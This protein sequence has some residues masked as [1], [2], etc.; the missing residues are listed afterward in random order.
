MR[1]A[2]ADPA[3]VHAGAVPLRVTVG[4]SATLGRTRRVVEGHSR[5]AGRCR[6]VRPRRAPV[7]TSRTSGSSRATDRGRCAQTTSKFAIM[8][9]SSCSSLWQCMRYTPVPVEPDRARRRSRV[10]EEHRVLPA[11]LPREEAAAAAGAG[12]HLEGRAVHVHRVRRVA[13]GREAPA[14]GRAERHL[15]VDPVHVVLEAVDAA[16]AVE[17]ERACRP[18]RPALER[19]EWAIGGRRQR[20]RGRSAGAHE[21]R[22]G[23]TA[24]AS[25]RSMTRLPGAERCGS[26]RAGPARSRQ[27]Q[28]ELRQP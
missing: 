9:M 16:H 28:V 18:G 17:A 4:P 7:V 26:P 23:P 3:G 13:A 21:L 14:L 12:H 5:S 15:E 8:P 24:P 2:R 11:G 22:A 10:V 19:R 27:A 25:T 1:W 20:S 6:L